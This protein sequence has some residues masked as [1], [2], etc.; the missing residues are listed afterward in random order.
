[1][2]ELTYED[3]KE[4]VLKY[5]NEAT[6]PMWNMVIDYMKNQGYTAQEVYD[7]IKNEW[8]EYKKTKK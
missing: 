1:M 8:K 6:I 2:K 4:I 3:L 5:G 7:D